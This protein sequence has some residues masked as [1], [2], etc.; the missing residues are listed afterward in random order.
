MEDGEEVLFEILGET[1]LARSGLSVSGHGR[2]EWRS[3][4]TNSER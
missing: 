2:G 4:G 1:R 3:R